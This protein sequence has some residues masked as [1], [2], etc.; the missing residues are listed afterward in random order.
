MINMKKDSMLWK[1]TPIINKLIENKTNLTES[2]NFNNSPI[3]KKSETTFGSTNVDKNNFFQVIQINPNESTDMLK[4]DI[5][6]SRSF[7]R[8][9]N[10][11]DSLSDDLEQVVNEEL[12]KGNF[13]IDPKGNFFNNWNKVLFF[14]SLYIFAVNPTLLAFP[15]IMNKFFVFMEIIVDLIFIV[16][17]L[18]HF[19]LAFPDVTGDFLVRK[20]SVIFIN[21]L[22]GKFVFDAAGSFPF[23]IVLFLTN[24]T[25]IFEGKSE[26]RII[27]F[28][29]IIRVIRLK[30]VFDFSNLKFLSKMMTKTPFVTIESLDMKYK[31]Q[32]FV[33]WFFIF[34]TISHSLT[35]IWLYISK[36]SQDSW[37]IEEE[38]ISDFDMYIVSLY[39]N[40]LS[41]F[42]IGYGDITPSG[43]YELI[44]TILM[45]S[46]GILVYSIFI[47]ALGSILSSNDYKNLKY[48]KQLEM[49]KQ[50]NKKYKLSTSLY[51]RVVK[52]IS[53]DS[54][55][56]KYDSFKFIED[57]PTKIKD[58][59]MLSL[60]KKTI[61]N[62]SF[63]NG[64]PL[65]FITSILIKMKFQRAI[66]KEFVISEGDIVN[67][68]VFIKEGRL[69]VMLGN[70]YK[71]VKVVELNK[72]DYFGDILILAN[73]RSPIN[74]I[75]SSKIC[76]ML[77]LRKDDLEA[78]MDEFPL[79]YH[80]IY[81]DSSERYG[82]LLEVIEEKIFEL[83]KDLEVA[84]SQVR[85]FSKLAEILPKDR[86]N[87]QKQ[88]EDVIQIIRN[89]ERK[90]SKKSKATQRSP[91]M[92]EKLH[93]S[94]DSS[95]L[96]VKENNRRK[97]VLTDIELQTVYGE[98]TFKKVNYENLLRKE[99]KDSAKKLLEDRM[100]GVQKLEKLLL[101]MKFK[102]KT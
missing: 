78:I 63:F 4:L 85:K 41:I 16:D 14:T 58:A 1:E 74:L 15:H 83:N 23:S 34:V 33:N 87:K 90:A 13:Y 62:F 21:Y 25:A 20:N 44:Y 93:N 81:Q 43:Y 77:Y 11:V 95:S 12:A 47:T 9:E 26:F 28:I 37:I 76:D 97:K 89:S 94:V 42:S 2:N 65:S 56:D 38:G 32:R 98:R 92:K 84:S 17:L 67:E 73:Q 75:C 35:C 40:W 54:M 96:Y 29:K 101:K 91:L 27:M 52:Y 39:F 57:L 6:S 19:F 99:T 10:V 5:Q 18:L 50:I 36:K 3:L 64:K 80:K 102:K 45:I 100:E 30:Q 53:Y 51:D 71:N 70:K 86:A 61:E 24:Y 79:V 60:N 49:L 68:I 66:R 72:Y 22:T 7:D 69:K 48:H 46:F 31:L 55:M 59:L 8:A 82:S 88:G